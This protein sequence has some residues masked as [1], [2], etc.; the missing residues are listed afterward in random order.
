MPINRTNI[1]D[2]MAMEHLVEWMHNY[3]QIE[4]KVPSII[5]SDG[6]AL[7]SCD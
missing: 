6:R 2:A 4:T 7:S 3:H 5:Y 1:A